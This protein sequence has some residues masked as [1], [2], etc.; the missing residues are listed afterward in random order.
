MYFFSRDM[1]NG[2]DKTALPPITLICTYIVE[3]LQQI[4]NQIFPTLAP[5]MLAFIQVSV[6][7]LWL[8]PKFVFETLQNMVRVCKTQR[9]V[10]NTTHSTELGTN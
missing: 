9:N 6:L 4:Q 1:R 3:I 5:E 8:S 2:S 10:D 7:T